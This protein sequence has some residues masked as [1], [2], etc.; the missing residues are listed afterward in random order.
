MWD[1]NCMWSFVIIKFHDQPPAGRQ[2]FLKLSYIPCPYVSWVLKIYTLVRL[3]SFK[4]T[5]M[6]QITMAQAKHKQRATMTAI[7]PFYSRPT[8]HYLINSI[9]PLAKNEKLINKCANI[10]TRINTVEHKR[11]QKTEGDSRWKSIRTTYNSSQAKGRGGRW[12]R[13]GSSRFS[14]R[15]SSYPDVCA[16][17]D[18]L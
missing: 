17:L 12:K 8:E 3:V 4:K 15:V 10:W 2:P 1:Q 9:T 13:G 5:C 18:L 6:T 11:R 16:E 14:E 7:P